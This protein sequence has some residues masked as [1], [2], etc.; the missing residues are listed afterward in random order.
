MSTPWEGVGECKIQGLG[1]KGL[2]RNRGCNGN[3]GHNECKA[4]CSQ[5][6]SSFSLNESFTTLGYK[7]RAGDASFAYLRRLL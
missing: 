3:M 2:G 1:M 6:R 7:E 5:H 4:S